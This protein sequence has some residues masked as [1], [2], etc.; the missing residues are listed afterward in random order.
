MGKS[1]S[2][3]WSKML[4]RTLYLPALLEFPHITFL[5]FFVQP[6]QS[7]PISSSLSCD[8]LLIFFLILFFFFF[9]FFLL[10]DPQANN[11]LH[12]P[13][14]KVHPLET[15]SI[16]HHRSSNS[17]CRGGNNG[18]DKMHTKWQESEGPGHLYRA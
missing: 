2:A 11:F 1:T 4:P 8:F 6:F 10:S 14:L 17:V 15:D 18:I 12:L 13:S 16:L 7:I 9:F 5:I 3:G